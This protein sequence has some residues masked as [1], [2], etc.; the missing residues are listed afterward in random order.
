MFYC[1]LSKLAV[2]LAPAASITVVHAFDVPLQGKLRLAEVSAEEI[3]QYRA[4]VEQQA[5]KNVDALL[6]E[7]PATKERFNR[8]VQAA[9]PRRLILEQEKASEADLIV[10]G[11][12]GAL[13]EDLLIGSVTR[14]TLSHSRC[15]VL[16]EMSGMQ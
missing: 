10:I 5:L 9:D 3:E 1:L 13:V 6:E 16:I 15:D 14:H 7:F 8:V 4:H 2:R 12:H 11:K